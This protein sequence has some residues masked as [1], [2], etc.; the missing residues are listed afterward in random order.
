MSGFACGPKIYRY[1]NVL[2]EYHSYCGPRPLKKDYEPKKR[3]GKK[4]FIFAE[5]FA[6]LSDKEKE[7]YRI[8]GGCVR[9]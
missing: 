5:K 9:I 4:F 6:K 3:A 8:G 2:F 1:E 7:F